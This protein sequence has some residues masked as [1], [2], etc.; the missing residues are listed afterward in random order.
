MTSENAQESYNFS[1]SPNFNLTTDPQ[2]NDF[3]CQ[4]S[5]WGCGKLKYHSTINSDSEGDNQVSLTP[6]KLWQLYA[7]IL[8][9]DGH[10]KGLC[11]SFIE[12]LEV[13]FRQEKIAITDR[14]IM[15]KIVPVLRQKDNK[16]S[17]INRKIAPLSKLIRKHFETLGITAHLSFSKLRES[18]GRI[19]FLSNDEEILL[20]RVIGQK[21]ASMANLTLFLLETG[22]RVGEAL[23]LQWTDVSDNSV[24]FWETKNSTPRTVPLTEEA[25]RVLNLQRRL[26]PR[27]GPFASIQ[28][29][30]YNYAWNRA[31]KI[32][33]LEHDDQFVPHCLRHTC[34]S[35]L[36]Q[37]G[38]DIKRIQEF[39]GHKTLTMTLR[40]AHLLP[41]HLTVCKTALEEQRLGKNPSAT[42]DQT[43][44]ATI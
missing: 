10:Y 12:E 13:I 32:M 5:I 8:W 27:H 37:Q 4:Y 44:T 9:E 20:L 35:R 38:V 39:L 31:R 14:D 40:Y 34:A 3:P 24:T 11:R 18:G 30:R 6:L 43:F 41:S 23:K 29:P 42:H 2:K 36:A 16:N 26:Y 22:A 17:T 33:M 25:Q 28:Y 15:D 19:R 21:D 1:C 7:D